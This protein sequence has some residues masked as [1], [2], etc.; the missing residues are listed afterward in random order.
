MVIQLV[1]SAVAVAALVAL[2]AWA[3]LA[4]PTPPLDAEAALRL[5]KEEF[6]DHC[7]DGVWLAGDGGGLIARSGEQALVLW[8][9]GD[10]YVARSASWADVIASGASQGL[11]RLRA[12]D[13]VPA[14]VVG[15]RPWPPAGAVG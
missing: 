8:R 14:L 12:V 6:P 15:D 13:G 7:V 2:A 5:L 11:I 10:G 9:R 4:R 3:R 1:G